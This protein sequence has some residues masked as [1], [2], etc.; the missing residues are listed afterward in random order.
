VDADAPPVEAKPK[1]AVFLPLESFTVNLMPNNGQAEFIQAGLTLKFEDSH[2]SELAKARMPEVR[3]RILMVLSS[4][5]GADLLPAAGKQKL[6]DELAQAVTTIIGPVKP[7]GK[8]AKP[9]VEEKV[10]DAPAA[11]DDDAKIAETKAAEA[12]AKRAAADKAPKIEVLFT[13]F[14]IQ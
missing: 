5:R 13:A 2:V 11:T 12:K 14:I 1:P 7:A 6:A 3:N 4:K 9:V 10:E 8:A